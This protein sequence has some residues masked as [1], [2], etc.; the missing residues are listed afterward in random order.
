M[1]QYDLELD[2]WAEPGNG[3]TCQLHSRSTRAA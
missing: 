2:Q 3:V 1:D